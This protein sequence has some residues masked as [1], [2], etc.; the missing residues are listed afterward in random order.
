MAPE[1]IHWKSSRM[2][3]H[4]PDAAQG[5]RST[6]FTNLEVPWPWMTMDIDTFEWWP[7]VLDIPQSNSL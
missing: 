3:F 1:F 2:F 6:T 5:V 4:L 7:L